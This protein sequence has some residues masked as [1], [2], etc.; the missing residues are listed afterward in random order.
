MAW[1]A[2]VKRAEF[3]YQ[4]ATEVLREKLRIHDSILRES[5]YKR[6]IEESTDQHSELAG[7]TEMTVGKIRRVLFRMLKEVGLLVPGIDLGTITRPVVPQI[8]EDVIRE[9]D[10]RWLAAFL[11]SDAE[12]DLH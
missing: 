4:F 12:V 3:L 10:P 5:D 6:F 1:L 7:M 11:F 8:V 2:A 9:D